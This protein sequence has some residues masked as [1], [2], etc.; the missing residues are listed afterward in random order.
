MQRYRPNHV[1]RASGPISALEPILFGTIIH[2]KEYLFFYGR[3]EWRPEEQFRVGTI[4][5]EHMVQTP[6]NEGGPRPV[7]SSTIPH[8]RVTFDIHRRNMV[9]LVQYE[10]I[11]FPSQDWTRS[12]AYLRFPARSSSVEY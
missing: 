1:P 6:L 12:Y 4:R 10:S 9:W 8:I 5:G 2:S 7:M 3:E 11:A